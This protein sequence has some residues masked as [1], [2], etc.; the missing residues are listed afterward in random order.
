MNQAEITA[1]KSGLQDILK[2]T[3]ITASIPKAHTQY[4][5]N[6]LKELTGICQTKIEG[7]LNLIAY[8]L[9]SFASDLYF[10]SEFEEAKKL[11]TDAFICRRDSLSCNGTPS[12]NNLFFLSVSAL[13]AKRTSEL[14][15]TLAES[16]IPELPL[17]S[18][19]PELV[20]Y[21][22]QKSFV[23][24]CRKKDDWKDINDSI[25]II[26]KLRELQKE[27]EENYL[28]ALKKENVIYKI[29]NIGKLIALYNA[30][31]IVEIAGDY[32]LKGD[33]P[34]PDIKLKKH[35]D[36]GLEAIEKSGAYD[37]QN[38]ISM[39]YIG[40]DKIIQNSIWF[41]HSP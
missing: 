24:L 14:R 20:Y 31:K 9:E 39:V 5:E 33:I 16:I 11:F 7:D 4:I 10:H 36:Q 34:T 3:G 29:G 22:I 35:R 40:C 26:N 2:D 38:F 28:G 15:L 30:A 41:K 23:L 25:E 21:N 17:D 18:S 27:C 6:S 32:L 19:W 37:L 12:L 13:G 8:S 1:Y